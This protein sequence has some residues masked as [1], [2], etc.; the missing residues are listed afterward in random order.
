MAVGAAVV[1]RFRTPR[2]VPGTPG[3]CL[4]WGCYNK[5]P[6]AECPKQQA[7]SHSSEGEDSEAEVLADLVPGE[8][9][10][11]LVDS[12]FLTVSS[13]GRE[14]VGSLALLLRLHLNLMPSKVPSSKYHLV[15]VGLQCLNFLRVIIQPL[16]TGDSTQLFI[17][18]P[19]L[20]CCLKINEPREQPT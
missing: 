20:F 11:W 18:P 8:A 13:H 3:Q 1:L 12:C 4:S 9:P 7:V 2:P 15:G 14:K 6:Q 16:T 19:P 17:N 10:P 5:T